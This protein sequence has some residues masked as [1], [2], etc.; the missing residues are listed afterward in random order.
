[1][2][3]ATERD[4]LLNVVACSYEGLAFGWDVFRAAD[5][6]HDSDVS[7]HMAFGFNLGGGVV[8]CCDIS[9]SGIDPQMICGFVLYDGCND[10]CVCDWVD[11]EVFGYWQH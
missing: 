7:F 4:P 8:K 10:A 6:E 1:M 2:E 9:E 5:R 11:R 3:A